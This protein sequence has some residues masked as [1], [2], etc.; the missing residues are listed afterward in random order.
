[1]KDSKIFTPAELKVL[2]QRLNN[3]KSDRTGL[4]SARIKPKL[5]EILTWNKNT[6]RRLLK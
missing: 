1:M 2:N 3:D 4:F 6:I 5:E